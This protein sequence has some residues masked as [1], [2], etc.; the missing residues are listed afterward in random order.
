ME[1]R[2]TLT[3]AKAALSYALAGS[4]RLTLVSKRTGAR[5]TYWLKRGKK[6]QNPPVFVQLLTGP[7]NEEDYEFIGTV[8]ESKGSPPVF[9]YSQKSSIGRT[10]PGVVA[11]LWAFRH[12]A[13]GRL[14]SEMEV[15]HEGRCGR[16]GRVLTVPSSIETGLGPECER[17]ASEGR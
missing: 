5:F 9:A 16:C 8:F 6:G 15:W 13:E 1:L 12:L 17:K 10:A 14:P 2:G 4:A 7:D 3:T 11:F